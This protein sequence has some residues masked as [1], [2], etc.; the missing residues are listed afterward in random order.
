MNAAHLYLP[1]TREFDIA[2][3]A[4]GKRSLYGLGHG[5]YYQMLTLEFSGNHSRR[6]KFARP[7]ASGKSPKC[8]KDRPCSGFIEGPRKCP[9]ASHRHLAHEIK[10]EAV[11][12]FAVIT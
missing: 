1:G 2:Q 12:V 6:A 9:T 4:T 5:H 7:L 8:Q 10:K 11:V 3:T